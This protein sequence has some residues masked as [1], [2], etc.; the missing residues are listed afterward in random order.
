MTDDL[1]IPKFLRRKA[2]KKSKSPPPVTQPGDEGG[3][4][5]AREAVRLPRVEL[6]EFV[7]LAETN[8]EESGFALEQGVIPRR[9]YDGNPESEM[10]VQLHLKLASAAL[11]AE[12]KAE[13]QAK[14]TRAEKLAGTLPLSDIADRIKGGVETRTLKKALRTAGLRLVRNR[15]NADDLAAAVKAVQEYKP[16]AR[17]PKSADLFDESAVITCKMKKNPKKEG[18]SAFDRWAL[19]MECGGVTVKEF[20]KRGGNPTTLKNAVTSGYALVKSTTPEVAEEAEDVV[21]QK[22]ERRPRRKK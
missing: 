21:P 20:L 19:L 5:L 17:R 22:Q 1:E 15:I 14:P 4:N 2:T 10:V 12:M 11:R 18:T 3:P 7:R 9:H 16:G 13:K 6:T 8:Y